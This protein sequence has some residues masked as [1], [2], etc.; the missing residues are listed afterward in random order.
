MLRTCFVIFLSFIFSFVWGF[1]FVQIVVLTVLE[2]I[3]TGIIQIRNFA[4]FSIAVRTIDSTQ[5][6]VV[7]GHTS[8]LKP[9]SAA[10]L[11]TS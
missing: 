10:I 2:I 7:K 11:M 1:F 5:L 8:L 6:P 4:T 3:R 9:A